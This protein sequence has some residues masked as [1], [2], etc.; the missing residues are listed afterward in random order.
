MTAFPHLLSP[1]QVGAKTIRNRVL[2]TGHV[3][4][5]AKSNLPTDEWVAYHRARAKGGAG[6]QL[7]GATPIHRTGGLDSS[8][9]LQ[10]VDDSIIPGYRKLA[11]AVHAEGG[12]FL[13]QLA[14]SAQTGHGSGVGA[15]MWAPSPVASDL[16]REIPHQMSKAEIAEIVA[17]YGA[18]SHRVKE[19]R[20]DGVE[21]LGAFGFLLAAFMSPKTNR[22]DDRY[23][24]SLD[25]RLRFAFEVVDAVREA[26]GPALIVGMR[27]A[28]DEMTEGGL[29][30]SDMQEIA[31]RLAAAGKLDYLNV[32]AG[33]NS[34]RLM[35]WEHW[36]PTPAPHGLFVPL[37]A[38]IKKVVSIPV[39]STG[40]I[41]D[42]RMAEAFVRD[43]KLDMVG[44]TRA[45]IADPDIVAKITSGRADEIRPCV[46]ANICID[47]VQAGG[48]LR[49]FHNAEAGREL[50]WG[51]AKPAKQPRRVA[52]IGAGPAGLE[53]ARVA[54][55][56]GH[57]VTVYEQG[58][59]IGGQL[60]LWARAPQTREFSRSLDWFEA[61]LARAQVRIETGR[62]IGPADLAKLEADTIVIAT[63]AAPQRPRAWPGEETSGMRI[64]DPYAV[65][66]VPPSGVEHAVVRDGGWGRAGLSAAELLAEMGCRVT[67][68]SA[69]FV[70][71]EKI[72]PI[73]RTPLFKHLLGHGA[74]LKAAEEVVRLETRTVVLRNVYSGRESRIEGV[75][76][77]VDWNGPMMV[78]EL[79]GAAKAAG[80]T[81]HVIG[82]CVSPRAIDVAVAEGALA[83]R[84]I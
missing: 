38:A 28:G 23:G 74:E 49:C 18:A 26:V 43:G 47:R 13:A 42:P 29:S 33:T 34:D 44:M 8:L 76:L 46:G 9:C 1:L 50:T 41:V 54:A 58:T 72:S 4:G 71:G 7:T 6:L 11:A 80:K 67:I 30:A 48:P 17:A 73:I 45:H 15:P 56:R 63:G 14:H 20:L 61:A 70:I 51:P 84:G 40:R 35:R 12:T 77:L 32:I 22:R 81:V 62:A 69:E 65:L 78:E 31:K 24:G 21:I 3:P 53:A 83:G 19:G 64:A 57:R 75:D 16:V 25:N 59:A 39:F 82:D 68:V 2:V 52:V 79:A 10:N 27:I 36:P 66:E 55:G 5:L 37:A 60:R